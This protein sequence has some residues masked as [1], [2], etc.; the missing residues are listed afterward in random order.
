MIDVWNQFSEAAT[1][2]WEQRSG[3]QTAKWEQRSDYEV[4][5]TQWEN[6]YYDQKRKRYHAPR[7]RNDIHE[8]RA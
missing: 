1:T 7:S 8:I 2:K 5:T 6:N 4:S 3:A